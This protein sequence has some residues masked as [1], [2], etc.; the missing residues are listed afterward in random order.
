MH[1]GDN[2]RLVLNYLPVG[3][4]DSLLLL[5]PN[6]CIENCEVGLLTPPFYQEQLYMYD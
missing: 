5:E 3:H 1:E 2:T 6:I 4:E